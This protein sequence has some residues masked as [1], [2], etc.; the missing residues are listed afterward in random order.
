MNGDHNSY[1]LEDLEENAGKVDAVMRS[2]M[3]GGDS[4]NQKVKSK[5]TQSSVSSIDKC[6]RDK[7]LLGRS[8]AEA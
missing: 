3:D 8:E 6:N 7:T 5:R 4:V 2:I 1:L